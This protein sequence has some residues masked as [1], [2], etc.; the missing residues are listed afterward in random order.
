MN[1][2]QHRTLT[3]MVLVT[4]VA[5]LPAVSDAEVVRYQLNAVNTSIHVNDDPWQPE[6]FPNGTAVPATFVSGDEVIIDGRDEEP[7]WSRAMAVEVPLFYG[8]TASAELKA[9]YSDQEVFIRVRWADEEES[10]QHRPWQWDSASS[11]YREGPEI[12]DSVLLSFEAGC[13]WAPSFLAGYVYD[14]DGWHWLAARSDPL[15]QALD[16]VGTI[17]DQERKHL[18]FSPYESRNRQDI[19][20]MKFTENFDVDLHADW[21]QLDRVYMMQPHV[22]T[23]YYRGEP[24]GFKPPAFVETV[25]PPDGEPAD[26]SAT[27]PQFQPVKLEGEAGEVSA[28]GTWSNGYWT[29]EFK[30]DRVTPAGTLNDSIFNRLT[31]FSV[32][33]FNA[34]E[35]VDESSES[36][37]LFLLFLPPPPQLV[38]Q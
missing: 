8:S 33:V 7:A 10:R 25:A 12:E 36:G 2:I 6:G 32:H 23:V 31:Q 20:N 38:D 3:A 9:L 11:T 15:G 28:R 17:Q 22:E 27:Y 18:P 30:R 16:L 1:M 19:W 4:F 21:D 14:F 37:R 5:G 24:D 35:R 26:A 29:V 34:T 13:E